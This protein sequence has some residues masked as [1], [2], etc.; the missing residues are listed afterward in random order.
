MKSKHDLTEEINSFNRI[1]NGGFRTGYS[2]KRNQVGIEKYLAKN[3]N[4]S[5]N[6]FEIGCGGGQWTKFI[7]PLVNSI[8]CN[9][10]KSSKDNSFFEYLN[11]YKINTDN[12]RYNQAFSFD[13]EYLEDNSLDFVFSYDVFCH[14]SLSG[15]EQYLKNLYAKCKSGC[16]LMIMYADPNKYA[17]NEPENT[18]SAFGVYR[19]NENDTTIETLIERSIADCD[20]AN[21]PDGR[22]YFVGKDNFLNLCS[23][24]RYQI[25]SDD[26]DIDKT[27]PITLFTKP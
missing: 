5:Y 23:K 18:D 16:K 7:A 22:W 11:H 12:I 6:V 4:S 3:L 27:N 17:N 9:D 1:W 8:V 10:A 21:I 24:Y 13:L 26:L 25:I 15:Q 19:N 14:I 2:V 20:G